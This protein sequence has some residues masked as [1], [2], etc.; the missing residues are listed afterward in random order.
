MVDKLITVSKAR[1]GG[2]PFGK[3]TAAEQDSVDEA[4][5]LWLDL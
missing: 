4:M 3:L 5:R 1:N 2:K